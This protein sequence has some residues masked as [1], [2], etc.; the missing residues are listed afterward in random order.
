MQAGPRTTLRVREL[1]LEKWYLASLFHTLAQASK[2][3]G[4]TEALKGTGKG[5][6]GTCSEAQ[7]ISFLASVVIECSNPHPSGNLPGALLI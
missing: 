3:G 6:Q 5:S 1:A 7:L 4:E 2:R